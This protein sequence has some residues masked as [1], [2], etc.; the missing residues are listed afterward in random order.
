MA[1]ADVLS[2]R[3]QADA[4]RGVPRISVVVTVY[5]EAATI[6]ELYRR[7]VGGARAARPTS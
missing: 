1:Q 4:A 3:D 2:A 7:T 6:E 5:N